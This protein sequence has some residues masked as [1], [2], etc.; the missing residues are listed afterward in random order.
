LCDSRVEEGSM[1]G[2]FVQA[3]VTGKVGLKG[4]GRGWGRGLGVWA[5]MRG[6]EREMGETGG[7]WDG[8]FY[9]V[10]M[11]TRRGELRCEGEVGWNRT[12]PMT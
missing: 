3:I 5:V 8:A 12:W 11:H 1:F 9:G 6:K 4:G 10:G 2:F 7:R